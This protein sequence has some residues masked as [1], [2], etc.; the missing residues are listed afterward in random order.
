MIDETEVD[1]VQH[2]NENHEYLN[3][4][5]YKKALILKI[6]WYIYYIGRIK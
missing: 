6:K 5:E 2:V 1:I 3:Y 4:I